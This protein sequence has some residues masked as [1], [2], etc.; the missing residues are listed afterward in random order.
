MGDHQMRTYFNGTDHP[1]GMICEEEG[2]TDGEVFRKMKDIHNKSFQE[3]N[4]TFIEEEGE[5][6]C[7]I[8][9]PHTAFFEVF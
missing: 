2:G 5:K 7:A 6:T 3:V 1:G 9:L 8:R 4:G